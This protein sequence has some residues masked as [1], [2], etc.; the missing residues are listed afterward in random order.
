MYA[1]GSTCKK[2]GSLDNALRSLSAIYQDTKLKER[3]TIARAL[4]DSG[5]TRDEARS[6]GYTVSKHLWQTCVH[7]TGKRNVGGQLLH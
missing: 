7:D 2:A 3:H 1:I 6:Y 5:L 4:R